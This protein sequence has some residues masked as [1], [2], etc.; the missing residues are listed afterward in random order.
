MNILA[1]IKNPKTENVTLEFL[2]VKN[3][4]WKKSVKFGE[5][6]DNSDFISVIC[7]EENG[8]ILELN[9]SKWWKMVL[10]L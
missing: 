8:Y 1:Y 5:I 4:F 2:M 6:L 9:N 3:F 10:I 7:N